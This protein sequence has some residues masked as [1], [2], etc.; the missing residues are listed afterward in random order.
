M[1]R[2]PGHWSTRVNKNRKVG[3]RHG[4]RSGL[5]EKNARHLEANGEEVQYETL[6]I[7]Y[8]VPETVRTYTPDFP[9]RNGIIVE[10]KGLWEQQDRAKLLFIKTQY[11]DLDIRLVFSRAKAPIYKGSKTTYGDWADKHGFKWAE[12]LIPVEWLREPG[13]ARPLA[14]ILSRP[15]IDL[16]HHRP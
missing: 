8:T 12:K 11:P 4:F 3:L 15:V 16:A 14:D 10:T 13:P 9:L 1:A 5:E 6:K 2:R 7:K